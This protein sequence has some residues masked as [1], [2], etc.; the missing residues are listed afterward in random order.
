MR[1]VI[2]MDFK[3]T[4]HVHRSHGLDMVL[5]STTDGLHSRTVSSFLIL[6]FMIL[7]SD[8]VNLPLLVA[9]SLSPFVLHSIYISNCLFDQSVESNYL[10]LMSSTELL[11]CKL[12]ALVICCSF[13]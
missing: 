9:D 7:S 8:T 12:H 3:I 13:I 4:V 11:T 10:K 5:Y 1:I 2:I 6:Y